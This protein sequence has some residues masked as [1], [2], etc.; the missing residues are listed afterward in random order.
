MR[1][2]E[3]GDEGSPR[4]DQ[5]KDIV[6]TPALM[7]LA[8]HVK[9]GECILFLGAGIH[10][11][12]PDGSQYT[13]PEEQRPPLGGDLSERLAEASGFKQEFPHE[14]PRDLQRVSLYLETKPG[15]GR[16]KLVDLLHQFL[17]I[18]KKPSP[19][20]KMLAALPF[21]IIVT[22]NYDRLLETAMAGEDIQKE[23]AI[24]IYN[25]SADA[26]TPDMSDDPTENRPLLF[27]MHGDLD[28]RD[29]IVITD[30]DYITF[31]QRM[32]DKAALHPVPET[33][34]FRMLKW[35]M[36]FAGY[37]LRDYNLRLLFRTLRWRIDPAIFPLSY[38]VDR[39][40]DPLILQVWQN[41]RKFVTF[42]AEDLWTFVP[43]LFAKV[44][45]DGDGE[46]KDV[47]DE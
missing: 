36:L 27:K 8:E 31:I 38:S 3:K 20:L 5:L 25:P 43:W 42:V 6:A 34:R 15:L 11:P 35:P 30:E 4:G 21:R 7:D 33:V 16:K 39:N 23:L 1:W 29:S 32:A 37:S 14:S 18:G 9:T 12:P 47:L 44:Q 46:G 17:R 40:P 24:L 22:T 41:E 2:R 19:A 45:G 26:P 10:A 13:Y 28:H